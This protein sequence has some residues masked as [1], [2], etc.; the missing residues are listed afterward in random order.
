MPK[1]RPDCAAA[2]PRV[3]AAA[4]AAGI[5]ITTPN[6]VMAATAPPVNSRIREDL[7]PDE[8]REGTGE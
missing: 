1:Y 4:S 7:R 6:A 5:T 2:A 8:R 3:L